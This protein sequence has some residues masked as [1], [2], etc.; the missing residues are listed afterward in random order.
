MTASIVDVDY[1]TVRVLSIAAFV[2][3]MAT[4]WRS[5]ARP[6]RVNE[7]PNGNVRTC[8]NCHLTLQGEHFTDFGSDV[9]FNALVGGDGIISQMHVDWSQVFAMDSD[10]D[11]FVNGIELGDPDGSWQIGDPS[12]TT[13]T[14]NPGDPESH[15]AGSCNNGVVEPDED[16]EPEVPVTA[17]CGELGYDGGTVACLP[18]CVLDLAGCAGFEPDA[19]I[20]G[21]SDDSSDDEGAEAVGCATEGGG[22]TG[23]AGA[24]GGLMVLLGALV[25]RARRTR[26]CGV[27]GRRRPGS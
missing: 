6:F 4:S 16:C 25:A 7:I 27:S 3:V 2:A 12:P 8:L 21:G 23:A 22:G 17:T 24:A 1:R 14:Y 26:N 15:P 10:H 20:G 11:T 18:G 19:G 13:A 5:E 9:K